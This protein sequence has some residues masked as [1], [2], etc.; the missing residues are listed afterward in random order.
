MERV[1]QQR[2]ETA[3]SRALPD[4]AFY[5][6]CGLMTGST[7]EYI[8]PSNEIDKDSIALFLEIFAQVAL[9]V[10]S[11]MLIHT[12]CGGRN[13]LIVYIVCIIGTQPTL[14]DKIN[15]LREK[16]FGLSNIEQKETKTVEENTKSEIVESEVE[17][18]IGA[19]SI[20]NLPHM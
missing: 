12:K 18:T 10:F 9:L 16:V 2:I 15:S 20:S 19:T 4:V 17:Q 1:Y 6:V 8:M 11:F 7:L 14:L 3:L 5:L 13:G